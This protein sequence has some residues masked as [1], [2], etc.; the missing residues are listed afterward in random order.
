[1]FLGKVSSGEL[2]DGYYTSVEIGKSACFKTMNARCNVPA[3]SALSRRR[4]QTSSE[5]QHVCS[6]S[7]EADLADSSS[8][9][10][11]EIVRKHAERA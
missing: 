8:S 1:M 11:W 6:G 2:S 7:S 3:I 5:V 10:P 4:A 9:P